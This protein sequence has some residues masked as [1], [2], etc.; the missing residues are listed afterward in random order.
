MLFASLGPLF[1]LG[2]F[3][4]SGETMKT[5][6]Y[7][8]AFSA[9][10]LLAAPRQVQADEIVQ[11]TVSNLTF[12]GNSACAPSGSG[13]GT[14]PCIET[15][16]FSLLFDTTHPTVSS[17]VATSAGPLPNFFAAVV[18]NGN[19]SGGEFEDGVGWYD[20]AGPSTDT[21]DVN[22]G[23][24]SDF[25]LSP[26]T[27]PLVTSPFPP[28]GKAFGDLVCFTA[29]CTAD[30]GSSLSAT[31]GVVTVAPVPEPSSMLLLGTGLLGML[32]ALRRKLI[33]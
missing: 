11:I 19:T 14:S 6:K 4:R 32:G 1:A 8:L 9:L 2:T 23:S 13:T 3:D 21:L 22:L 24:A 10:I 20:S 15:L 26:G 29:Q 7:A 17:I 30:F 16:S 28:L 27:Y 31:S 5:T 33:S 25:S 12:T 18:G